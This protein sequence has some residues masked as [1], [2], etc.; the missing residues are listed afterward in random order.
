MHY[1]EKVI[2][3]TVYDSYSLFYHLSCLQEK[4]VYIDILNAKYVTLV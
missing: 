2:I 4:R 3:S 1:I